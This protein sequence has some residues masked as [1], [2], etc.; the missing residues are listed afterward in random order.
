MHCSVELTQGHH[1]SS[2]SRLL[3]APN[4][5]R[6]AIADCS[7]PSAVQTMSSIDVRVTLGL[8]HFICVVG[9]YCHI[10]PPWQ[11][12]S[13]C[14]GRWGGLVPDACPGCRSRWVCASAHPVQARHC[15]G[16]VRR[17]VE[18]EAEAARRGGLL[19]V[20]LNRDPVTEKDI[21]ARGAACLLVIARRFSSPRSR[22][23]PAG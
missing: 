18:H 20:Q 17:W 10:F 11:Q 1:P 22:L 23:S 21:S 19:Q 4:G 13:P 16:F 5:A 3:D 14:T 8:P 6:D 7:Y 2:H 12:G 15:S 9:L